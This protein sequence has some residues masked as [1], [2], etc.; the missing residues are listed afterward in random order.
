M[1]KRKKGSIKEVNIHEAKTHLSRLLQLV[2]H[3]QQVTIANR[4]VPVAR[5]VPVSKSVSFLGIDR[6]RLTV[7]ADFNDPLPADIL[8]AF[9]SGEA[10]NRNKTK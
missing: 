3:G 6:D 9:W 8:A 10:P 1:V 5:L 7:P 4:G 2:A